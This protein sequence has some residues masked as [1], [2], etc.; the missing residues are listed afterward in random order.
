M[1][2]VAVRA[3]CSSWEGPPVWEPLERF[4][5]A[6]GRV[7]PG[8]FMWMGSVHL[9]DGRVLEQY[10]A[11]ETRRYLRLDRLGHAYRWLGDGIYAPFSSP[12]AAID[13]LEIGSVWAPPSA[14][15]PLTTTPPW[16]ERSGGGRDR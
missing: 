4:A 7:D 16:H 2:S 8:G 15:A 5:A 9:D 10:K 11:V 13:A 3:V 6:K 1:R 14:P 12:A